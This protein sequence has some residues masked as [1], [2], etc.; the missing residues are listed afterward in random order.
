MVEKNYADYTAKTKKKKW[1]DS[2]SRTNMMNGGT[3]P[4][5]TVTNAKLAQTTTPDESRFAW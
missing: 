3:T 4:F 1:K 2:A 5:R